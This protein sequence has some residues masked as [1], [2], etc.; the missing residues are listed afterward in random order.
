MFMVKI[1]H[2]MMRFF[3]ISAYFAQLNLQWFFFTLLGG[4]IFGI[5]PATSTLILYLNDYRENK[6]S[7]SFR[8]FWKRCLTELRNHWITGPI[9]L[10]LI[11]IILISL[12]ILNVYLDTIPLLVP[13]Y[14]IATFLFSYTLFL[15]Y[16]TFIKSDNKKI[17]NCL[18]IAIFL[19]FRYPLQCISLLF[20]WYTLFLI[21]SEKS[22]LFLIFGI[23][24][25][26]FFTEF[27]HSQMI[28]K[29]KRYKDD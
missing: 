4:I 23:S 3:E 14:L 1:Q 13:L 20:S 19:T 25:M 11:S 2:G 28:K 16:I 29:L 9:L 7:Y 6:K 18:K 21:F 26:L 27:F 12:R 24:F 10:T 17:R 22:S 15:G 5:G 8:D